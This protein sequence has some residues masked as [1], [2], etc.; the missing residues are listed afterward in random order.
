MFVPLRHC[1][2]ASEDALSNDVH[3]LPD[4]TCAAELR[5]AASLVVGR[6]AGMVLWLAGMAACE[7]GRS[8]S[9]SLR[10]EQV[11]VPEA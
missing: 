7:K 11:L 1:V 3:M 9:S 5:L 10:R 4:V 6:N 8:G 2:I